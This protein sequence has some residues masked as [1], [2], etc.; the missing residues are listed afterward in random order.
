MNILPR[1]DESSN[2][3]IAQNYVSAVA[4][5]ELSRPHQPIVEGPRL[6]QPPELPITNGRMLILNALYAVSPSCDGNQLA[7]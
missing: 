1:V 6:K 3:A 5:D 4:L 2:A 7:L